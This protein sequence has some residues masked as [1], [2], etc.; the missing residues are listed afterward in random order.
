[1][2]QIAFAIAVTLASTVLVGAQDKKLPP[3]PADKTISLSGCVVR[4][5]KTPDQFTL[6]D[7]NEGKY[8]LSGIKLQDFV[9]CVLDALNAIGVGHCT[10]YGSG[11]GS[12][13]A[14]QMAAESGADRLPRRSRAQARQLALSP[15]GPG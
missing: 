1:M 5:E 12:S 2:R 7:A 3:K 6:E 13:L 9:G 8:R 4:N 11:F 14:L 15:L 10:L